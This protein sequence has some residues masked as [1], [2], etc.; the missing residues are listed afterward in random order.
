MLP[1]G[2]DIIEFDE[3]DSTNDEAKRLIKSQTASDKQVIIA[4][5]QTSGRGRYGREWLSCDDN[6]FFSVILQQNYDANKSSQLSF[7]AAVALRR[8]LCEFEIKQDIEYKWPNDI[9]VNGQKISGILL[10]RVEGIGGAAWLIV[11]IGVNLNDSP[12]QDGVN[13]TNLAQIIGHKV[14]PK[15]FAETLLKHLDILYKS[16]KL[17]GFSDIRQQWLDNA[18][19]I[20]EEIRV[21][22][23][24]ES[25]KGVFENIDSDGRL[26]VKS[27]G[28]LRE[29]SSGE[30]FF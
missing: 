21:N 4:K 10:E 22:L 20:G 8:A 26:V 17:D 2:Y 28:I 6:L 25:F 16:W 23:S 24:N 7:L 29:I 14:E 30:V 5:K 11:G 9:L 1:V 12:N 18:Y 19:M 27:G 15:I 3:I 13:A